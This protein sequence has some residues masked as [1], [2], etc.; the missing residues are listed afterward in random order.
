MPEFG[1]LERSYV[2]VSL[3]EVIYTLLGDY[4]VGHRVY[5]R[6][7]YCDSLFRQTEPRQRYCP[8]IKSTQESLCSARARKERL[9]KKREVVILADSK[10]GS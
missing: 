2:F 3:V 6:C 5:V 10:E 9:R 1:R 7:K 4:A 8:N